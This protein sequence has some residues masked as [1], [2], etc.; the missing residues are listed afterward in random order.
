MDKQI[1]VLASK[2][3]IKLAMNVARFLNPIDKDVDDKEEDMV[4]VIAAA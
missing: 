1:K 3:K 2:K 4:N